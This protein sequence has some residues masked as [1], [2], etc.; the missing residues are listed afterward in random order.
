VG[1]G[2][3]LRF[4]L[5]CIIPLV[6]ALV[7]P[8]V[9]WDDGCIEREAL[10]FI[11][12]YLADRSALEKVFD[13]HANDLGTYQARELS[14]ALDLI[15]A[16]VWPSLARA[17]GPEFS[18]SS[19]ALF[20]AAAIVIVA[21]MTTWHATRLPASS[22]G[23]LLGSFV[24]S[25]TFVA[26]TGL[27]YRSAKPVLTAVLVAGAAWW[28][29]VVTRAG[30]GSGHSAPAWVTRDSA[31]LFALALTAGLL[32]R[33]G[34]FAVAVASI[35]L[36][37]HWR[38]TGRHRDGVVALVT[39]CVLLQFYNFVLGPRIVLALNGYWPSFAYQSIPTDQ[40]AL[41]HQLV[42]KATGL[43]ILQA[44]AFAGGPVVAPLIAV[45]AVFTIRRNRSSLWKRPWAEMA[46]YLFR[47]PGGRLVTYVVLALGAVVVMYTV[48]IA[49]H[50][51]VY[52][53]SDH[54]YWYY[55]LP[56]FGVLLV[57]ALAGADRALARGWISVRRLNG[58][59]LLVVVGNCLSLT[60]YRDVMIQGPWFGPVYTQCTSLKSSFRA[61]VPDATLDPEYRRFFDDHDPSAA[62]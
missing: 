41:V 22:A 52:R 26:T 24:T 42:L 36:V 17:F 60:Y 58:I 5:A 31:I 32:D 10:T 9:F 1:E 8:A 23:L 15:D 11:R 4:A 14:Y 2:S 30:R 25:F 57:G 39:A 44:A 7:L 55:P 51:Y 21:A 3:G 47:D 40:L 35:M 13:P 27:F 12:Q 43:L 33:Q 56:V 19:S 54:R 20:T 34:V 18:V 29:V 16:N 50:G 61:G 38:N 46:R 59:L 6:V 45:L 37:L 49:R 53:W 62:R 48:M 28:L